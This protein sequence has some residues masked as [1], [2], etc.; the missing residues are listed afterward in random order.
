M[1]THETATRRTVDITGLGFEPV[2]LPT[3][4]DV[5]ICTT[6]DRTVVDVEFDTEVWTLTFDEYGQLD[7]AP[8]R[9]VPRWL[10]PVI[11][12]AAPGLRVV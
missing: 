5:T 2:A 3:D 4:V 9:S 12:K 8:A 6:D 11:K 10:G 7:D 1:H